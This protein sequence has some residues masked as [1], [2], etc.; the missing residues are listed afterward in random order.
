MAIRSH[1]EVKSATAIGM[2]W[3]VIS[4]ISAV[5]IGTVGMVYLQDAPLQGADVEKIFMVLIQ[6]VFHPLVAGLF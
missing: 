3:V 5:L 6:A 2:F 1:K 4:L